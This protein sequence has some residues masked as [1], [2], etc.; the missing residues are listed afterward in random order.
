MKAV[1]CR[2]YLLAGCVLLLIGGAA[3]SGEGPP[4]TGP[5]TEKRF[6]PLD[7]PP[8]FQA[9]LFACDPLV[10]Y[11]SAVALGPRPGTLLVAADYLTGLGTEITRRD[12]VRLVEDTDGDGYADRAT[13]YAGQFNSIQ[14]LT[15]HD[16]TLYAMHAPLLTALCDTDGDGRADQRRD[17]LKGL[18][19]PPEKNPVRLHCANGVAMGHDGWLYLALGDHGCDVK[20][21]E[22]DRLVLEGGGILRCRPDGRGAHLFA[23]GLRNIYDVALDGELNVFVR[24]NEN[25]GGDYKVRVCHSFFGADHGYP[26]LYYERPEE[27]LPPLA[28]LGLGSSAGGVCYQERQFPAEFRGNL[29]FCEWGRS[30]VR[31]T[32]Q[33]AGSGFAPVEEQVFAVGAEDDPYGFKPTDVVVE[34]DGSLIVADWADNQRPRR[35]RGRI[36]RIRYIGRGDNGARNAGDRGAIRGEA[37]AGQIAQLD[38][39][40]YYERVEAQKSIAD[41][42]P[43]GVKALLAALK[44]K[45]VAVRGRLH[46]VWILAHAGGPAEREELFD[47][48]RTDPDCRVKGQAVRALADIADPVLT[49][50]RRAAAAGDA[51]TAARI[52]SLVQGQDAQVL[53]EVVIAVGRLRWKEAPRWLREALSRPDAAL[54][55]AAMQTLR[56]SGNWPAVLELL[57]LPG[58]EPV[59]SVAVRAIADQAVPELVDGLIQRLQAERAPVRR[60]EYA[61]AL[62]RVYK[63]PGPWV[64]WGY[65]PPPRPPNSIAWERTEAIARALDRALADADL[66]VRLTTLERMQREKV[67]TRLATL[68]NRLREAN[69]SEEV[70]AIL[71]ALNEHPADLTRELFESAA[72]SSTQSATARLAALRLF[73]AGLDETRDGR[74]LSL[75]RSLEDGPVLVEALH[76]IGKRPK[77]KSASLLVGKLRSPQAAVRTAAL[78]ALGE[79]APASV[80]LSPSFTETLLKLLEDNDASVRRAAASAAGRLDVQAGSAA[81]LKL[82]RDADAAVRSAS[83]ASL[84]RLKDARA[85]SPAVA[86][87]DD[88]QTQEAALQYLA[89]FGSVAQAK[90][91]ADV[92]RSHP[93][94]EVLP[95]ALR[96]LTRWGRQ[97]DRLDLDRTVASIQGDS[98]VLARW[99]IAG[100]L[101]ADGALT[102]VER[103]GRRPRSS[104]PDPSGRS[105]RTVF[106]TG[107]ESRLQLDPAPDA[108]PGAVW[109]A[110]TDLQVSEQ[111]AVEFLAC[112]N[113]P[114]K[115]WLNGRLVHRRDRSRSFQPDAERFEAVLD[116][117]PNRLFVELSDVNAAAEWHLRF[118]CKS[119]LAEHERLARAALSRA[120]NVQRGRTVFLDARKSQC[121]KCHRIRDEG[122]RIGPELTGIGSR[123]SRIHLVESILQPSRTIA[124]NYQP[125][126]VVLRDG[127]VA[128]GIK[129]AETPDVLTLADQQGRTHALAKA[130]IEEQSRNSRSIMPEGLEKQLTLQ[131]FV[132]LIAFLT[133]QKE[134]RSQR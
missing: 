65:R 80:L 33:R 3:F 68:T 21:P 105:W 121:V 97:A 45:R 23:G 89:E 112:S 53:R 84:R 11:P 90:A 29:F 59:R 103:Q 1:S 106:G 69:D 5:E 92:A 96:M 32:L 2:D 124:P 40:S 26:Y 36:Y 82:A 27:A 58:T 116:E 133:A 14:G 130:E 123:F 86:A 38:S 94:A 49:G 30:V 47:L 42:G 25:D 88:Q 19:L 46:A 9:T 39:D 79:L 31:Y 57:D 113:A 110:Y 111:Q 99:T 127:R 64:Y 12:E 37:L 101:P 122:E 134:D 55:H 44:A 66:Q 108:D 107:V 48:A 52:A 7:V 74:L 98:G 77:S 125:V 4:Q 24:D 119:T 104:S 17:L 72:T 87:L 132:D 8:G 62:T 85:V 91:V 100:P 71:E 41:R 75:A 118:R 61:D 51:E 67:P 35:G 63:K 81:L 10:E 54:A 15:F 18:G 6:P 16:G 50:P 76:E 70:V 13:V 43:Q 102:V 129:V 95:L 109:L 56:R 114:L 120:G 20:R 60:R 28:D 78:E 73:V 22:G 126:V 34:R 115:V 83:L 117:G 93:S 131:E 128:T